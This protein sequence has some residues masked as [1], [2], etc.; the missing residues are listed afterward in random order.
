MP[1][2]LNIEHLI[3]YIKQLFAAKGIYSTWHQLGNISAAVVYLQNTHT[4]AN[5]ETLVSRITKKAQDLGLNSYIQQRERYQSMKW[6]PNLL[7]SGYQKFE[8]FL[9]AMFNKKI[10]DMINNVEIDAEIDKMVPVE[11]GA[12]TANN[13]ED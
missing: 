6:T 4:T 13:N 9:L 3:G 12:L 2:D 1:L 7:V 8:S 5:V 11:F 10:K